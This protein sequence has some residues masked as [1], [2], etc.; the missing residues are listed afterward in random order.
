MP[1]ASWDTFQALSVGRE[2]DEW[3]DEYFGNCYES[4]A[5]WIFDCNNIH[6][7][8]RCACAEPEEGREKLMDSFPNTPPQKVKTQTECWR[9]NLGSDIPLCRLTQSTDGVV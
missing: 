9:I 2:M 5:P 8:S 3:M 7:T 1:C 6:R 4:K